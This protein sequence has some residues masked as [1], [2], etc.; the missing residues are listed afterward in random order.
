MKLLEVLR[1]RPTVEPSRSLS[2]D[3]YGLLIDQL[4]SFGG[5]Q[6][7]IT[8][9]WTQGP[10]EELDHSYEQYSERAL[11]RN[12]VVFACVALRTR[13]FS[14]A[15]FAWQ[16]REGGR[17]QLPFT[18]STLAMLERPWPGGTTQ[19]LL[20]RML[21]S[22]DL[23]G[24]AYVTRNRL[25]NLRILRPDWVTIV[26]GSESDPDEDP[27]GL[28]ATLIGYLYKPGGPGSKHPPV[29]L[30]A[31]EVAHFAPDPDP[32]AMFRG[33]S[34]LTPV[35]REI[36][37][38]S[39]MS[40]H[41][42]KFLENAA[43]PNL[44]VRMDSSVTP[45]QF[46]EFKEL[47]KSEHDGVWNA[48]K[49]MYLG[50]GAD[51]TVAGSDLKQLDF[52]VVQGH[53]ETRIA[54]AAGVHPVVLGLS[55]GMQG[56][57]LNAG[58]YSQARRNVADTTFHPLWRNVAGTLNTIIRRNDGAELVA[59]TRDVPFLRQ[60]EKDAADVAQRKAATISS[61]ISAGFT[62]ESAVEAVTSGDLTKL[63][64]TGLVSVQLQKPGSATFDD[65]G[66]EPIE[67]P[68]DE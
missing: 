34:W 58:N 3:D 21:L 23:G 33:M 25:G 46:K 10:R 39:A 49:T 1:T 63:A 68:D 57:S 64:H 67:E 43:T 54:A 19:D 38:D 60:D 20:Q 59:D 55:E 12:G 35:A 42:N 51:V 31:D 53:G 29:P 62:P 45:E 52:K 56:S 61:M 40:D 9:T 17:P 28:D 8:S 50:G 11:K 66:V 41:K 4:F 27:D 22:A 24:N 14:E 65:D 26:R 15:R 7:P 30:L 16:R 48:Y 5:V 47:S 18:D 6:Y 37:G 36:V 2:V 32:L 44:V 13:V